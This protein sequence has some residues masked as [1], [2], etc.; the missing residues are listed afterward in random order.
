[1]LG[2]S[3]IADGDHRRLISKP[4][5]KKNLKAHKGEIIIKKSTVQKRVKS[6]EETLCRD[7]PRTVASLKREDAQPSTTLSQPR[8]AK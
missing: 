6:R 7:A 3:N 5:E 1:M 4:H 8:A 2:A